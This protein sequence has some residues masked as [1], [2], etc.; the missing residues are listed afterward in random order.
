MAL[1]Q[2]AIQVRRGAQASLEQLP[3]LDKRAQRIQ[4]ER[5]WSL[6]DSAIVASVEATGQTGV[7]GV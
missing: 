3:I 5:S 4:F 1:P 2:A 6:S 7:R